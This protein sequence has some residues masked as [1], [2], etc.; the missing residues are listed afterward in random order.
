MSEQ[1]PGDI[2]ITIT[3]SPVQH[4]LLKTLTHDPL[5]PQNVR[6][7]ILELLDHAEQ[8]VYRPGAWERG[9]L[10]QAFGESFEEHLEAGDPWGRDKP[11]RTSPFQRPRGWK[12]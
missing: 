6:G 10:A 7:V 11:G 2:T 5:G 12:P 4:A 3:L 8:G 1:Q 9:W